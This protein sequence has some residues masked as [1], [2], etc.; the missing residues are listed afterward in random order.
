MAGIDN[1]RTNEDEN[2]AENNHIKVWTQEL[3]SSSIK[4]LKLPFIPLSPILAG[5][6]NP[7]IN[8][9]ISVDENLDGNYE[10]SLFDATGKNPKIL[11]PSD[12][13]IDYNTG[14]IIFGNGYVGYLPPL[15]SSI[16]ITYN[17]YDLV[18][19]VDLKPAD[20]VKEPEY[21]I[22]ETNNITITWTLPIDAIGFEVESKSS[23]NDPWIKIHT[24]LNNDTAKNKFEFNDENSS[25]GFNYYRI[26]SIDRMGYINQ[27]MEVKGKA[28]LEVFIQYEDVT[29]IEQDSNSD[30]SLDKFVLPTFLLLT[31][32]ASSAFYFLRNS[33]EESLPED[34]IVVSA[35][36]NSQEHEIMKEA[37][38][39]ELE[40][41]VFS[42]V[43]GSEYS[44]QVLFVCETGCQK[45]FE[46]DNEDNEIMCPHCGI[47]GES[48][49]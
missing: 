3:N 15:N 17:G 12:Y 39:E 8:V 46:V 14:E 34:A 38:G 44:R 49:I 7:A 9:E 45:E 28:Y 35:L 4:R 20:S 25:S 11:T 2:G 27:N 26:N 19:V 40:V 33:K 24:V 6:P 48:P 41:A 32:A 18:T 43:S 42:V 23:L 1:P 16:K 30:T 31:I 10:R 5:G 37:D 22:D 47:M 21:S 36:E 29:T 13:Q